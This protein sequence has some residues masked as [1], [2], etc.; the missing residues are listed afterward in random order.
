MLLNIG[1]RYSFSTKA[2][3]I[4]GARYERAKLSGSVDYTTANTF[5]NVESLH[6]SVLPMLVGTPVIPRSFTYYIFIL[7]SGET[8]VFADRWIDSRVWF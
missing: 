1:N 7:E 5:I 3:G 6:R 8:K 2:P 4:L